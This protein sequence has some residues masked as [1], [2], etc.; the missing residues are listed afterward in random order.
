MTCHNPG[1]VDPDSTNTVDFKVMVHKIH[2]GANLPSVQEGQP[3]VIYGFRNSENDYSDVKFPQDIRNCVNCH[4][5][6]ATGTG[7]T[8]PDG[9]DYDLALTSQGD[10]WSIYATQAACGSCHDALDFSKHAG[11]QTD[12]SNCASCHA[13]DGIAGSIQ[14][15]HTILTDEARKAFAA[16]IVAVTDTMPGEFPTVQYK[17]LDPTNGDAPYDL[18]TDPVWT[19]TDSGASRL[20]IDL[21][22][23]TSDYTNTGNERED[24]SAVSLDALQ[25]HPLV[26]AAIRSHPPCRSRP[27]WQMAVAWPDSRATLRS[28]SAPRLSR[29][30]NASRLPM[31]ISS[32]ASTKR[33]ARQWTGAHRW[34][35]PAAW[36]A[37][38]P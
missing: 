11:G 1:S 9:T 35:W 38:R 24:A 23:P 6:S 30:S 8:F 37:T 28:I 7:L 21:A 27:L 26:M 32:T 4:A 25:G 18:M 33:T 10:N 20:A 3:Y 15:S 34:S 16:E 14:S 13:Q 19:Q 31:R 36:T 22:W 12:D 5:G 29:T 17:V 2:M